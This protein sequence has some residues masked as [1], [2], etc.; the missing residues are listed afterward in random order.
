MRISKH[1]KRIVIALLVFILVQTIWF[2]VAQHQITKTNSKAT[3]T[4][5]SIEYRSKYG[6]YPVYEFY[7]RS[8]KR[9]EIDDLFFGSYKSSNPLQSIL[10]KKVGQTATIY[11]P[12]NDPEAGLVMASLLAYTAWLIPTYACLFLLA[13]YVFVKIY[14][15][16]NR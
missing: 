5:I 7:D 1:T 14:I 12:P 9:H 10:L 16:V 4:V 13:C 11:Y 2:A 3:G 15:R 8:G 6:N